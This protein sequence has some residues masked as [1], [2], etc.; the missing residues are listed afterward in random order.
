MMFVNKIEIETK[1]I[2]QKDTGA[3]ESATLR[4]KQEDK[5][6]FFKFVAW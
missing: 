1:M 3:M 6:V 2:V 4:E 5:I